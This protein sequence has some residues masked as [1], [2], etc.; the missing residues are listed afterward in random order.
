MAECISHSAKIKIRGIKKMT[1]K[2]G[3]IIYL[4]TSIIITI[5]ISIYTIWRI[6]KKEINFSQAIIFFVY[7]LFGIVIP[8]T[9][10]LLRI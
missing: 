9:F 6:K 7:V 1:N 2:I 3:F 8:T 10:I 5:I 4:I